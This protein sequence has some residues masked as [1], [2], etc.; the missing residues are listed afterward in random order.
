MRR[1]VILALILALALGAVGCG[2]G[3][4]SSSSSTS[5]A[6]KTTS[7]GPKGDSTNSESQ[8]PSEE[9][10]GAEPSKEFISNGKNGKLA[11]VGKEASVAEREAA[12]K[13]LEKSLNAREEG[14]WKTQCET[15]SATAVE[16][17]EKSATVL[18]AAP[19]CAKALEAQAAPV[20]APAR[21]NTMTGPIDALRINQKINGFAF[22]HGTEGRDFV[23]PLIKQEGWKVVALQEEEIR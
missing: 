3:S 16:G 12:S 21:A 14:D 19:G 5:D 10:S 13:V 2:G 11:K 7:E 22:Y 6:G 1:T 18:G 15:L 20:P 9:S 4:D 17:V 8:A 23:I